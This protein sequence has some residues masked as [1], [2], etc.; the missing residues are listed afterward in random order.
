MPG[1]LRLT[2]HAVQFVKELVLKNALIM[3]YRIYMRYGI[4]RQY[5]NELFCK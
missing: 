2:C 1:V 5:E 4:L 3:R